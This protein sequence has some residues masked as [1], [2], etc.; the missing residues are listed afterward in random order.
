MRKVLVRYKVK[1]ERV[2]ENEALVRAVYA[3]LKEKRPAGLRYATLK[4][5]DGV[6]FYHLASIEG[7]GN[8]LAATAAF[9]RFQ[10]GLKDRCDEPPQ[11]VDLSLVAAFGFFGE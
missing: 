3:E 10:E 2:E 11:P 4:A 8:P 5:D 1:P 9:P 7:E 6:T